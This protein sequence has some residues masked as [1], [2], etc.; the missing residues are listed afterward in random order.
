[1]PGWLAMKQRSDDVSTNNK[2]DVNTDKATSHT[3][4]TSMSEHDDDHR[5]GPKSLNIGTMS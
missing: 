1:M 4:N 5:N 2:E 3:P